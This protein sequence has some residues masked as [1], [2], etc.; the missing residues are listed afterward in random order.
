MTSA[1]ETAAEIAYEPLRQK[2][3]TRPPTHVFVTGAYRSGTTLFQ[4]LLDGHPELLVFPVENAIFRDYFFS[5]LF[6]YPKER[7]LAGL[8]PSMERRDIA[9]ILR[10]VFAHDKLSLPLTESIC[11]KGSTGNQTVESKFDQAVF[12]KMFE[13]YLLRQSE[14]DVAFSAK[15]L[16]VAY[17]NAYYQAIG[18]NTFEGKKYYVNKCPEKGHSIDF[19]LQNFA[20]AKIIHIVRDPRATIASHKGPLPKKAFLPYRRFML[21]ASIVRDAMDNFQRYKTHAQVLCVKYKDLVL[22]TAG[23][24]KKVASFLDIPFDTVILEPSILGKP[25]KSNSSFSANRKK[26][27]SSIHTDSIDNWKNKLNM[28]EIRCV[29][30]FCQKQMSKMGYHSLY[31]DSGNRERLRRIYRLRYYCSIRTFLLRAIWHLQRRLTK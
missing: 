20:N 5:D 2:E 14:G 26:D 3:K 7:T 24:M 16:F 8:I 4:H 22:D 18:Q 31:D 1:S 13:H 23:E 27:I 15:D 10:F 29:E 6:P 12:C 11:L 21:Q 19:C 30:K 17:N 25:W 9:E 28:L